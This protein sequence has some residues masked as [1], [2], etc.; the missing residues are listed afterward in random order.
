MKKLI[1]SFV[2]T[3]TLNT[4]QSQ[5]SANFTYSVDPSNPLKI[6]FTETSPYPTGSFAFKYKWSVYGTVID[7][8]NPSTTITFSTSGAY[9]ITLWQHACIGGGY[10]CTCDTTME[11]Q[12]GIIATGINQLQLQNKLSVYPNPTAGHI[13]V[14]LNTNDVEQKYI[15]TD[16]MGRVVLNGIINSTDE[17]ID[18]SPFENGLYFLAIGNKVVKIIKE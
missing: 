10:S 16:Q 3:L 14:K 17:K 5:C 15:V 9:Q 18:L 6:T 13:T 8:L 1:L 2:L 11:V 7:S 4:I 12:V